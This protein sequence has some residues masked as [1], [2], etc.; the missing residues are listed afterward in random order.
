MGKLN[1]CLRVSHNSLRHF[2]ITADF[3]MNLV[4]HSLGLREKK[5]SDNSFIKTDLCCI[6]AEVLAGQLSS[7]YR[8]LESVLLA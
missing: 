4:L 7:V 5:E 6:V 1:T 8:F 2:L 3:V